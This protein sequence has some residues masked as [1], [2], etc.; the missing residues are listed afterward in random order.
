[1]LAVPALEQGARP[2]T[3]AAGTVGAPG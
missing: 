1:V 3:A 2:E